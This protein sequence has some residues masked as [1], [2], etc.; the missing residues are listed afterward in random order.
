MNVNVAQFIKATI[1]SL[2]KERDRF[3]TTYNEVVV[4]YNS[5]YQNHSNAN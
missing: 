5:S 3:R 4:E 1:E 2:M